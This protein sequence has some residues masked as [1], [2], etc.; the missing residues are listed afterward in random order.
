MV[1]VSV[2]YYFERVWSELVIILMGFDDKDVDE[3][4]ALKV[5][6][7]PLPD[8]FRSCQSGRK[9]SIRVDASCRNASV[10]Q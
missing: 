9:Q 7:Y 4:D 2:D 3:G 10:G 5:Q 6:T 8:D 1:P